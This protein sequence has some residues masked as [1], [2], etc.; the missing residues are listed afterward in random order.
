MTEYNYNT[1]L[2][3]SGDEYP[4]YEDN[5]N[6]YHEQEDAFIENI[7]SIENILREGDQIMIW[8]GGYQTTFK[9][10][11]STNHTICRENQEKSTH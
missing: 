7:M 6:K 4:T 10:M 9:G 1:F 8:K 2:S 5:I 11:G 3:D